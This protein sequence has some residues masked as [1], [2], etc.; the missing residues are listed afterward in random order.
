L[1]VRAG[2]G[3]T[4]V[5]VVDDGRGL[6]PGDE[7]RIFSP[8]EQGAHVGAAGGFGLGLASTL[9][10]AALMEGEC[11]VRPRLTRGAAFYIRLRGPDGV[12]AEAVRC[13]A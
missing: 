8:F 11:G 7:A 6:A 13:A 9:G 12:G 3:M 5:W 4:T 1:G 10:L 2:R